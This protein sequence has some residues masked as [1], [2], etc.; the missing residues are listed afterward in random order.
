VLPF[1]IVVLSV[2]MMNVMLLSVVML[3]AIMPS[4]IMLNAIMPSVVML[5]V[6]MPS[7]VSLRDTSDELQSYTRFRPQ[8]KT[9]KWLRA[10]CIKLLCTKTNE[11]LQ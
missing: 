5:N 7:V 2:V 10:H 11:C 4:V 8:A 1:L 9:S 3:N 6:I